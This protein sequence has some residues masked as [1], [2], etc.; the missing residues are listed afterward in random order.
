MI[1]SLFLDY[2][3]S[4]LSLPTPEKGASWGFTVNSHYLQILYLRIHLATKA[5]LSPQIHT[6]G[7]C[8][9]FHEQAQGDEKFELPDAQVLRCG[10]TRR[11]CL[12]LI[13]IQS[14]T[15]LFKVYLSV[16]LSAFL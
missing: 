15:V 2:I 9:A 10:Q 6:E 5:Y 8:T 16:L 4:S 11:C 12:I 7:A 13:L 3:L 1:L 14:T